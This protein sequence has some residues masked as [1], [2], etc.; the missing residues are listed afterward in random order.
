MQKEG[1]GVGGALPGPLGKRLTWAAGADI[2]RH[3]LFCK[4]RTKTAVGFSRLP[5]SDGAPGLPRRG[6]A[7]VF[8]LLEE[9]TPSPA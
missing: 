8:A 9:R 3:L 5:S 7:G 4:E 6:T 1:L 2:F